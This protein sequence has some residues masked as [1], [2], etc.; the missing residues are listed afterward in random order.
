MTQAPQ[1]PLGRND[2][3][4]QPERT[5]LAW[6]RTSLSFVV[7]SLFFLRWAGDHGA[8]VAVV[9][10]AASLTGAATFFHTRV[11]LSRI[12][13][14]FPS[15]GLEPATTEVFAVCAAVVLLGATALW[16]TLTT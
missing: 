5:S 10:A 14:H 7:V 8:L 6:Q 4:L 12:A 9:V 1:A 13:H 16:V 11:R 2:P 15:P 3:G